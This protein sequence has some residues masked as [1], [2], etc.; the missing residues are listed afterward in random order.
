MASQ[1]AP[2]HMLKWYTE[3]T[4]YSQ[5]GA[6]SEAPCTEEEAQ[7]RYAY[8]MSRYTGFDAPLWPSADEEPNWGE[9]P[10]EM[11]HWDDYPPLFQ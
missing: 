9:G 8:L 11:F 10:A 4:L 1:S 6:E 7:R 3:L 5:A 2:L